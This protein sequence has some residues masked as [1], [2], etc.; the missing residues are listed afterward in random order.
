MFSKYVLHLSVASNVTSA[1]ARFGH[2][3]FSLQLQRG[4]GGGGGGDGGD[5]VKIS[6]RRPPPLWQ[7]RRQLATPFLLTV[8]SP[9]LGAC[10]HEGGGAQMVHA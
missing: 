10:A 5:Y 6:R 8:P 9:N 1:H 4:G 7:V 2:L 3:L